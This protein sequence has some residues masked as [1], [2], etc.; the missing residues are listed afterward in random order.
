MNKQ[1]AKISPKIAKWYL[2]ACFRSGPF[3]I[4]HTRGKNV[5]NFKE[6]SDHQLHYL[7]SATTPHGF[8]YKLVDANMGHLPFDYMMYRNSPAYVVIV[9]PDI[10]CAIHIL[11]IIKIKEKNPSI[12]KERAV[13]KAH[14]TVLLKYIL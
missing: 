2:K 12:S 11:D 7:E 4:K 10:V 1:E 13:K 14:F 5:F 3:E 6:I 8:V 9:Y